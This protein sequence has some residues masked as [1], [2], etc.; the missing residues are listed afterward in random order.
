MLCHKIRFSE[1]IILSL[2]KLLPKEFF[3]MNSHLIELTLIPQKRNNTH[4]TKDDCIIILI[5]LSYLALD[6]AFPE[7]LCRSSYPVEFHFELPYNNEYSK[8]EIHN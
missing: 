4:K 6:N 7:I 2:K 8:L 1:M 5:S 3:R